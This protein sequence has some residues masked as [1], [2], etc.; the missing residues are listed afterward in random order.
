MARALRPEPRFGLGTVSYAVKKTV[1]LLA[2]RTHHELAR[3]N[4]DECHLVAT[5]QVD[6]FLDGHAEVLRPRLL[7][8]L[9]RSRVEWSDPGCRGLR[10][11]GLARSENAHDAE[12][13]LAM[14]RR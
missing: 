5:G 10:P 3:W 2:R 11:G 8:S 9:R 7:M 4:Q 13:V 14:I 1:L 6:D 12:P